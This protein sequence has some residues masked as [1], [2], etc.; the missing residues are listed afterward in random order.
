MSSTK[1]AK[2]RRKTNKTTNHLDGLSLFFVVLGQA[3]HVA[4]GG[5]GDQS[6]HGLV[7][8]IDLNGRNL[9]VIEDLTE[10]GEKKCEKEERKKDEG[11]EEERRNLGINSGPETRKIKLYWAFALER[12]PVCHQT[13]N[14]V[15]LRCLI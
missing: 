12:G 8:P 6:K 3:F 7:P 9:D 13:K 15:I 14:V 5:G 4:E 2:E 11:N 1:V 10:L